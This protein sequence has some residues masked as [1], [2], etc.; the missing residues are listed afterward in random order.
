LELTAEWVT[1]TVDEPSAPGGSLDR[2][3]WY[4]QAFFALFTEPQEFGFFGRFDRL[5]PNNSIR[6]AD[7]RSATSV[8]LRWVPS[9]RVT[10]KLEYQKVNFLATGPWPEE[11]SIA[12]QAVL[13]F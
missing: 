8:G 9:P 6:D 5:D 1:S 10:F 4:M 13:D 3:G 12:F 7:D 11:D 2:H